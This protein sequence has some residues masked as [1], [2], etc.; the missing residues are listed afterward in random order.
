MP[1][2]RDP[3]FRRRLV[4]A[5]VLGPLAVLLLWMG[6]LMFT[7]W[8]AAFAGAMAWEWIRMSDPEAPP[9][10]YV[11]ACSTATGA[12]LLAGQTDIHDALFWGG[13]GTLAIGVERWRRGWSMEVLGV[14]YISLSA[15]LLAAMRADTAHGLESVVL[16]FGI[17]WAADSLAY[18]VGTWIGGPKLIPQASPNKTW[19]GFVAGLFAGAAAGAVVGWLFRLDLAAVVMFGIVVAVASVLGDLSMSLFKRGFGVKDSG[20]LIPGHGGVLDRVDA[21]MLAVITSVLLEHV[22]PLG[23]ETR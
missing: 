11:I 3:A 15:G 8:V 5:L 7:A 17:V 13:A 9:L 18:L 10:A 16:L 19:S 21:L 14:L 1:A 2:R 20:T 4:S 23:W 6:G 12:V 22:L